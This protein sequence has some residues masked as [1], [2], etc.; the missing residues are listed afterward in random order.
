MRALSVVPALIPYVE[1]AEPDD[2]FEAVVSDLVGDLRH[3]ADH[4]GVDWDAVDRRASKYYREV[5]PM[6]R[7]RIR[8][9]HK[10][11]STTERSTNGAK[12]L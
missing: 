9:L 12:I 11:V 4:L 10:T 3:L 8:Q 2:N 1:E 7:S 6:P 5:T